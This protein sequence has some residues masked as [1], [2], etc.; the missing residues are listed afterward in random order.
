MSMTGTPQDGREPDYR[1][2]LANE[3]TFLAWMRTA[4]AL[5][6]AAV[7]FH[8]FAVRIQPSWLPAVIGAGACVVAALMAMAGFLHWRDNQIAMR[9]DRPLPPSRLLAAVAVGMMALS[10][11]MAALL[12]R[13]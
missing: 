13:Q 1:F 10:A 4:L 5:L 11:G 2:S 3:R 7:L 12:L 8:Q 6:A 9:H